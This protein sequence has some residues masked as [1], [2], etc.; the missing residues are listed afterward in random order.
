MPQRAEL[1][2]PY[3]SLFQDNWDDFGWKCRFEATLHLSEDEEVDLGPLRIAA[4][5]NAFRVH[6]LP[7]VLDQ[8]P[9]RSASLGESV[10]YYR[11]IRGLLPRTRRLYLN[12][13][14]DIV[15]RPTRRKRI[16]NEKLW[17]DCFMRVSSSRHA[18]DRGGYYIGTP[19]VQAEPPSFQF[20]MRLPGATG[21]HRFNLDF[22][23]HNDLPNRTILLVG[24]NGTGKT[25][26]LAGLA[27]SV[28]PQKVF[29]SESV[30]RLPDADV[31]P[32]LTIS[33]LIAVSYNAFDEF[34]LPR[35]VSLKSPRIGG[36]AYKSRG[37]YKY[38]GLRGQD[39]ALTTNEIG[40]M[41]NEALEPV[42][43]SDRVESLQ[44]VL[45]TLIDPEHAQA[46]TAD[47]KEDREMTARA[48][49]AGQRLV[50]SIFSNIIGFIEEGSLLLIDEPETNLHPGLLSTFV[51]ALNET[52][53]EFDSYA[54]VASHSP[55]LLQQVP[56]RYVRHFKRNNMDHPQVR[57]PN[58]ET[59]GE[60]LGE[61]TRHALGLDDPEIDFTNVLDRL[62]NL[63]GSAKAV[64]DLFDHPLGIPAT[65]H[66]YGLESDAQEPSDQ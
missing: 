35:R 46:L 18:L 28:M 5:D 42:I 50:V 3:I 36:V 22:S 62:F 14:R 47:D 61:L 30:D 25:R 40:Q 19:F 45:S 20:R 49:S 53:K 31:T 63:H 44:R 26:A 24:R 13:V 60:D 8:L 65:A 9:A 4:D 38:C 41:L 34:P 64:A 55:I 66:L 17:N 6:D 21:D 11:K 32:P 39:G 10:A 7:T 54:V 52:L 27:A 12:T 33:R 57:I 37:S 1:R 23:S 2:H 43:R 29:S 15:A 51:A 58:Y 48:L 56:S 16:R 59:F